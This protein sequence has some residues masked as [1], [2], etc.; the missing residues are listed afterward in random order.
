[1]SNPVTDKK[2]QQIFRP[3]GWWGL[4]ARLMRLSRRIYVRAIELA[5]S[6]QPDMVSLK[7]LER[8]MEEP[9]V[10]GPVS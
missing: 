8:A 9:P 5:G 10:G 6:K 7:D 3:Q 1:M 2:G 4:K